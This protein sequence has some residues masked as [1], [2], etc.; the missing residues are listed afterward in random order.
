L[1]NIAPLSSERSGRR[2]HLGILF[3]GIISYFFTMYCFRYFAR[4]ALPLHR[5]ADG[6]IHRVSHFAVLEFCIA[7]HDFA[8]LL[9]SK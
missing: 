3:N 4:L 7:V 5:V 6:I 9:L 1:T 8:S 2:K